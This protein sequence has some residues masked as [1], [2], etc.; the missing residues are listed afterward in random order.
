MFINRRGFNSLAL[1]GLM[2]P[3]FGSS[4]Q[5]TSAVTKREITEM[6]YCNEGALN[7]HS[8]IGHPTQKSIENIPDGATSIYFWSYINS[9]V[10]NLSEICYQPII[11]DN[12]KKLRFDNCICKIEYIYP[13]GRYEIFGAKKT[14]RLIIFENKSD[15]FKVVEEMLDWKYG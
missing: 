14:K 5:R 1:S 2:I 7:G 13:G 3:Y 4:V 8:I 15:V 11:D 12:D 6:T 10:C 9:P